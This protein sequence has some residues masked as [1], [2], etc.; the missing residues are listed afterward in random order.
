MAKTEQD[1]MMRILFILIYSLIVLLPGLGAQTAPNISQV[2]IWNE[3]SIYS[4]DVY[5]SFAYVGN[6]NAMHILDISDPA[7]PAAI[8]TLSR[9]WEIEEI[10]VIND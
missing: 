10:I 3:E 4:V 1:T 7:A 2:G 5:G 6:D 8:A 9:S